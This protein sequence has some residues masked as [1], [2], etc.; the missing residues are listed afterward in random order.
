MSECI[1]WPDVLI[2]TKHACMSRLKFNI[3]TIYVWL[4]KSRGAKIWQWCERKMK[5]QRREG[6]VANQEKACKEEIARQNNSKGATKFIE[7]YRHF[8]RTRIFLVDKATASLIPGAIVLH[9]T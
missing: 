6:Q 8:N 4:C 1:E 7:V 9:L 2:T 5:W 3:I